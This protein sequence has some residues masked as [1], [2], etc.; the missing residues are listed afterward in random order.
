MLLMLVF[1]TGYVAW[2][3]LSVRVRFEG[4]RWAV[5]ARIYARPLEIYSGKALSPD[6][7]VRELT[8]SGYVK[9]A[10]LSRPGTYVQKGRT[11]HV[12]TRAF[13]F[14]DSS[15]PERSISLR[16]DGRSVSDVK[17]N[18]R[19]LALA[20]LQPALIGRIYPLHREDR[21]LV[22]QDQVPSVLKKGLLAV[23]DRRFFSHYGVSPRAIARALWAN[24]RAGAT[25]QGGST[26]TQ[27]LAKNFFL[28][29]D[30]SLLR[31]VNEAALALL[32]EFHYGK[33]EL[34]EAYLNE[35]YLGQEGQRAIHGFGLASHF[36]FNRPLDE[37]R[38]S[39][40]ALLI[41]LVRGASFY[42]PRRYP[43]RALKRRNLV[44]ELMQQQGAITAPQ[45]KGA[46]ASPLG[47]TSTIP[48]GTS[49]YPA[50]L[51]LIK[52]QLHRDY[53]EQDLRSDG[54]R[55]FTTLDPQ[56]Q[57]HAERSIANQL[58]R[59]EAKARI[60]AG[61]L[62]GAV[63]VTSVQSGEVLAIVGDRNP[64]LKAFNRAL[65]ATRPVGSLV[66]PA[67]YL[68]ALERFKDYTLITQLDD[69]PL[70]IKGPNDVI[71]SPQNYDKQTHG[72]VPLYAAL[73]HSYNL[74]TV[75]LGME[76]GVPEVVETLHRL[77][78]TG[79]IAA[80]PSTLLGTLELSP[81]EVAQMY[82]TLATGGFRTPLR[83]IRDVTDAHGQ[84][85]SRYGLSIDQVFDPAP[86]FLVNQ[87]MEQVMR[88]GTGRSA[89]ARL[90]PSLSLAGKT[91]TTD[92]L[93]D[94]WFAGFSDDRLVVVWLGL[95]DNQPAGLTGSSG[96]L[97]VWSELM[98]SLRPRSF[99]PQAPG[100]VSW[101]WTN[102]QRQRRT[103]RNCPDSTPMPFIVG[104]E[105]AYVPCGMALRTQNYRDEAEIR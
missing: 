83:A 40:I 93:R 4:K 14:W 62:Q 72:K 60:P 76:V 57:A 85:L 103:D 92:E 95:D 74:A 41:A 67:V 16:F 104:S 44:L 49:P 24:L 45:S 26:L 22:R 96:A 90:S 31:K 3:D 7:F 30:R 17:A 97:P 6:E 100:N 88:V 23:E 50:F 55:I 102:V 28:S 78:V 2:L 32:L 1:I 99:T 46:K 82:H 69:T 39:E 94:S 5:P 61:R 64:R 77:G 12:A 11:F 13:D 36:Y 20:R 15:E 105:P 43:E 47:V 8:F 81:F 29:P 21:V 19:P 51:D 25:V 98:R 65:D 9:S 56:V 42:D 80:Y 18:G 48:H 68:T 27:Q 52:R 75:R 54:L 87:A 10:G 73:A 84:P 66:K 59:L 33:E 63:V 34:L 79:K 89:Y 35:I 71:W 101:Y 58:K 38:L 91:G 37:L 53:R 70:R 86:I